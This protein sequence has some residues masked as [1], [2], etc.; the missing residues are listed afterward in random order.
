M[1]ALDLANEYNFDIA[2]T[3]WKKQIDFFYRFAFQIRGVFSTTATC[4]EEAWDPFKPDTTNCANVSGSGTD[5]QT[6]C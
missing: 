3:D 6:A 1:I 4:T 5:F 2:P